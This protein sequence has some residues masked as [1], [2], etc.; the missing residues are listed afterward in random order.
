MGI[1]GGGIA[2]FSHLGR[3]EPGS[4]VDPLDRIAADIAAIRA[5]HVVEPLMLYKAVTLGAAGDTVTFDSQSR[6]VSWIICQA[7]TGV[8]DVYWSDGGGSGSLPPMQFAPTPFP[9]LIPVSAKAYILT[10]IANGGPA[11]FS[12]TMVA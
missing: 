5:A 9:I 4:R 8:V 6:R 10:A 2:D 1:Q 3:K 12:L 7:F 11:T